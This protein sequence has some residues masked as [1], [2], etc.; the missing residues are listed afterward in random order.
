[1]QQLPPTYVG[2]RF[3]IVWPDRFDWNRGIH[4]PPYD[5]VS[6]FPFTSVI[7]RLVEAP[8]CPSGMGTIGT[9]LT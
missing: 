2:T 8:N 9:E 1:M 5:P 4:I 6:L 7:L 3:I